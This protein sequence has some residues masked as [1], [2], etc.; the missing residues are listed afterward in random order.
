MTEKYDRR[1]PCGNCPFRRSAPLA[2]WHPSQYTMLAEIAAG[3]GMLG[4]RTFGCHKDR[5]KPKKEI[6]SC[7]GWL[8]DQRKRGIPCLTLRI[9]LAIE[10]RYAEQM[11]EI[12]GEED[13]YDSIDEV[14]ELNLARDR[15]I[16]PCRYPCP[17]C[18]MQPI[19]VG[20][21]EWMRD[22]DCEET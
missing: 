16:N 10:P 4:D 1:E 18:G 7:V 8:L 14:V 15:E 3:E 19:E 11:I 5:G 6:G 20:P 13:C 17:H 2:Y 22:C 12:T 21:D 9:E